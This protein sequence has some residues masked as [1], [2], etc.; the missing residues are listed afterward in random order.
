MVNELDSCVLHV[1]FVENEVRLLLKGHLILL[2]LTYSLLFKSS[3]LIMTKQVSYFFIVL[4]FLF[5]FLGVMLVLFS[6]FKKRKEINYLSL[7]FLLRAVHLVAPSLFI[8]QANIEFSV[9]ITG[10]IKVF[11]IPLNYLFVRK[12]FDSDKSWQK[13]D[14]WHFVP[15]LL[16]CCLT[17]PIAYYH[18]SD[19][20]NNSNIDVDKAFRTV[21]DG[22]FYYTL[23]STVGR[24]ISFLQW[25][26]YFIITLPLIR[27]C[28]KKLKWE[29]S[30]INVQYIRWLN[31]IVLVF[32]LMGLFEGLA[33]FGVYSRPIPFLLNFLFLIFYGFYFFLFVVLFSGEE[34]V[35][36]DK[37]SET[38]DEQPVLEIDELQ[39]LKK[40]ERDEVYLDPELTLQKTAVFLQ[41]P[42]YKLTQS[43]KE[44][45]YSS[46]YSFV[47]YYRVERSKKLLEGLPSAYV[48]ESVI[49]DAGF[50]SRSTFFRVFKELTGITPGQYM[51]NLQDKN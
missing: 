43:I 22:N 23:L 30:N 45:G 20:V 1:G 13:R 12:I 17:F 47:N 44:Q 18:A 46:F 40:F 27:K 3:C 21:W 39:W 35:F 19:V 49:S 15:F 28:I 33:I 26:F 37:E 16:N 5:A 29:R 34:E 50:K 8:L 48:V 14:L 51:H 31:G 41:L 11:I 25:T 4:L 9:W 6:V 36:L 24:S 10:P 38:E 42:K 2:S 7:S 32:I